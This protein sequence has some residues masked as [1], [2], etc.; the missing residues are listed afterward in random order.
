MSYRQAVGYT[1]IGR[2]IELDFVT[3]AGSFKV[4]GLT[5]ISNDSERDKDAGP[6]SRYYSD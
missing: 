2:P 3:S 5:R 1:P 4:N 6:Q